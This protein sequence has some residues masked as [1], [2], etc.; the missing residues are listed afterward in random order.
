M[1]NCVVVVHCVYFG[2]VTWIIPLFSVFI[3]SCHS[4]SNLLWLS[5]SESMRTPGY[6]LSRLDYQESSE[7][8]RNKL[9]LFQGELENRWRRVET[10]RSSI[11]NASRVVQN[12]TEMVS[13]NT[14]ESLWWTRGSSCSSHTFFPPLSELKC[15]G[16]FASPAACQ[17]PRGSRNEPCSMQKWEPGAGHNAVNY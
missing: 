8:S 10:W 5:V 1:N 3:T 13:A 6:F 16:C 17:R 2:K 4:D 9:F 12:H 15:S 14:A 11:L 7:R